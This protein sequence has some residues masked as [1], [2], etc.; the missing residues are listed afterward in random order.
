MKYI[1]EFKYQ[2]DIYKTNCT[3]LET[4]NESLFSF[5]G[6][7]FNKIKKWFTDPKNNRK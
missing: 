1:K 3:E 5:L 4:I 6:N 7:I 2:D